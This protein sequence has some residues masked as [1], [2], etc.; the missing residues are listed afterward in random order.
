MAGTLAI[1]FFLNSS[2]YGSQLWDL[3]LTWFARVVREANPFAANAFAADVLAVI[4]MPKLST[5]GSLSVQNITC[6]VR[7]RSVSSDGYVRCQPARV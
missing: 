2:T 5:N 1:V 4:L 3:A 7:L 6:A